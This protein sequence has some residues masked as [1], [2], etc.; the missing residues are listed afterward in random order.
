MQSRKLECS[1]G[2]QLNFDKDNGPNNAAAAAEYL[3]APSSAWAH[4]SVLV[5]QFESFEFM[6]LGVL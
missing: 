2:Y 6:L 3:V 4:K 1:G 5:R